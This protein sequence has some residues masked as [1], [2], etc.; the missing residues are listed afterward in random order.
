MN[1]PAI[2][3]GANAPHVAPEDDP[4]ATRF[5][6][7]NRE[8]P[9]GCL[10]FVFIGAAALMLFGVAAVA[11][12]LAFSDRSVAGGVGQSLGILSTIP[13][14]VFLGAVGLGLCRLRPWARWAAAAL[15]IVF[16]L[17]AAAGS[18]TSEAQKQG[19][20]SALF[21]AVFGAAVLLSPLLCLTGR[22]AAVLF[23]AG[24]RDVI[25]RTP[26][27]KPRTSRGIL[28]LWIVGAW[29]ILAQVGQIT[30]ELR[31]RDARLM[32]NDAVVHA[33]ERTGPG[34]NA[35]RSRADGPTPGAFPAKAAAGTAPLRELSP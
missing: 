4:E 27:I 28:F 16:G 17:V 15:I 22:R 21:V 30:R 25:V 8:A 31:E 26:H 29:V 5:E 9:V 19:N 10:G 14:P 20:G 13:I 18:F 32:A 33:A 6:Y 34:A 1:H 7:V 2:P 35:A 24:Y 11:V 12:A 3:T 23:S